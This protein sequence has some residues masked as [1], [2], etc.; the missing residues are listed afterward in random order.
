MAAFGGPPA[1]R[2]PAGVAGRA[3]AGGPVSRLPPALRPWWPVFKRAHRIL[4]VLL[5]VLHRRL[6]PLLGPRAVPRTATG[7][8][9]DTARGEPGTVHLHP[10]GPAETL[11]RRAVTGHPAGHWRF[12][13]ARSAQIPARYTL[14]VS[15]GRLVGSYGA[16][17][18]PCGVL[19][20]QT[21][22]YFGIAGWREH[23]IFLRPTVGRVVRERGTVLSLVTRGV[24]VN[25]YHF[26]L[27][28]LGRYGIFEQSLPGEHVDAIVVPH[29]LRYQRELL[30]LAG[31]SA[32]LVE[33]RA[34]VT[35]MAD[36]LLVPS[37][38]NQ[39]LD[40]PPWLVDWLRRRLPARP[41]GDGPRRL[42][43]S[44]GTRRNTRSY[45]QEEQ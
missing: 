26:L 32:R 34:G 20:Y 6:A 2:L 16:T 29:R 33:P 24:G 41:G 35:I 38:P 17:V 44:R 23:P 40:A 8:S 3:P 4:A 1:H 25:Y 11:R 9:Q 42:Y 10:A 21:S 30:G 43:L 14:A 39:D 36:R 15:G 37:T 27:D 28:G 12:G 19:D 5:G 45:L 13:Q 7:R 22:G 31:V 18:T